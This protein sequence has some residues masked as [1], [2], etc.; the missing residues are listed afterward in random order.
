MVLLNNLSGS[1]VLGL[2]QR[3]DTKG[4]SHVRTL[5]WQDI[6]EHRL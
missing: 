4:P 1:K 5:R 2:Q 6:C 3:E